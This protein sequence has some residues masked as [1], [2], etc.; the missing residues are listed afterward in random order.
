MA[1]SWLPN[2]NS[3]LYTSY[4]AGYPNVYQTGRKHSLSNYGGLNVSAS[5]S[6]DNKYMA[7]ILS[8][9]GNPELYLKELKTGKL[10]RLTSTR[11][12]NEASPCWS[13]YGNEI[14]YVSDT[15][16]RTH[17]YFINISAGYREE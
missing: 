1:P 11:G 14:A 5:I 2:K 17:I 9:D 4:K 10:K 6:P 16:G 3:V 15:S 7:L 8:K 13:P 12:A